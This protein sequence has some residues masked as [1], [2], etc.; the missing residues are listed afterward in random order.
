[1]FGLMLVSSLQDVMA[2]PPTVR[3]KIEKGVDAALRVGTDNLVRPRMNALLEAAHRRRQSRQAA[4]E[5]RKCLRA[6]RL[7]KNLLLVP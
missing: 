3:E 2:A 5:Q 1:M 4:D 6:C 7:G